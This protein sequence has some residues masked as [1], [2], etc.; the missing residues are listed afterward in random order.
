MKM[1][2]QLIVCVAVVVIVISLLLFNHQYQWDVYN[3]CV[4]RGSFYCSDI[5]PMI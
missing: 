5:K 4:A 1:D 2:K 3:E